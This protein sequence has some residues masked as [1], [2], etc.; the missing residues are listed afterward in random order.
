MSKLKEKPSLTYYIVA[1]IVSYLLFAFWIKKEEFF[2]EYGDVRSVW[3]KIKYL[4][5]NEVVQELYEGRKT[6]TYD[7]LYVEYDYSVNGKNYT[8]SDI[9]LYNYIEGD[10][11]KLEY[12]PETPELS[13]IYESH[14]KKF[15]FFIRNIIPVLILSL[16]VA[17]IL[18]Y[19][20]KAIKKK[21]QHN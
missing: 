11:I 20:D 12:I 7:E 4:E 21:I 6:V 5:E 16:F 13:R 18:I 3:G 10:S 8:N 2:F 15:N 9:G 1:I 14:Q 17:W 19:I